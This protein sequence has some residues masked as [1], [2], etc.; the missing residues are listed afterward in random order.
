[1]NLRDRMGPWL[2]SPEYVALVMSLLEARRSL[3]PG[4]VLLVECIASPTL[5]RSALL[6][7]EPEWV[8]AAF[9]W[10]WPLTEATWWIISI[11]SWHAFGPK[12][13][14]ASANPN[15]RYL[16]P[17]PQHVVDYDWLP[18]RCCSFAAYSIGCSDSP[19]AHKHAPR[20]HV[21]VRLPCLHLPVA[22]SACEHSC[23][24]RSKALASA[25]VCLHLVVCV[26]PCLIVGDLCPSELEPRVERISAHSSS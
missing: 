25:P 12:H 16:R 6:P 4:I 1:M 21:V 14:Q 24:L 23:P 7:V 15:A 13:K 3:T 9:D 18:E 20:A 26:A 11:G 2:V 8:T 5:L 17:V 10:L 22:H 19:R